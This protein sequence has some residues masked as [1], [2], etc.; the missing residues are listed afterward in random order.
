MDQQ[1]PREV[2]EQLAKEAKEEQ[3]RVQW[4]ETEME[5]SKVTDKLGTKIETGILP[6]V[7]ALN[8]LGINTF[9]SCE[10]HL[11]KGLGTPTIS[12]EAKMT[13]EQEAK[14][15]QIFSYMEKNYDNEGATEA[16]E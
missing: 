12:I 10:G 14:M 16:E 2:S 15:L 11:D 7:V 4:R 1:L 3:K 6:T 9:N 5:L 8:I 13:T